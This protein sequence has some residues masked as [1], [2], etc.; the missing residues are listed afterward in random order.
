MFYDPDAPKAT[1]TKEKSPARAAA[2]R[3]NGKLAAGKKTPAGL[4]ASARNSTKHGYYSRTFTTLGTECEDLYNEIREG[5]RAEYAP[6]TVTEHSLVEEI[7]QYRWL[8]QRTFNMENAHLN[9]CIANVL[10]EEDGPDDADVNVVAI[11]LDGYQRAAGKNLI[12]LL[13]RQRGQCQRELARA[14]KDLEARI[15]ARQKAEQQQLAQSAAPARPITPRSNF[16]GIRA[17]VLQS[18]KRSLDLP[19]ATPRTE[20]LRN[21]GNSLDNLPPIT[22]EESPAP[23][24]APLPDPPPALETPL[25]A[26]VPQLPPCHAPHLIE[27]IPSREASPEPRL[28]PDSPLEAP[29]SMPIHCLHRE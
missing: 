24:S 1:N 27:E 28:A 13:Y 15:A 5:I 23:L 20:I 14:T 22:P 4:A 6:A 25:S 9:D 21:E 17:E 12:T 19:S 26:P 2:G 3:R 18:L 10:M 11:T 29:P 7:A 8:I 16:Y